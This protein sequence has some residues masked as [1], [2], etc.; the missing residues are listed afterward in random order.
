MKA[1]RWLAVGNLALAA[2]LM[3][4]VWVLMVWVGSR[5]ALKTLWDLTPQRVNSVDPATIELL[6]QLRG[7]KTAVQF[8]LMFPPMQGGGATEAEQQGLAIRDR[9]REL[10]RMLLRGY[11]FH[12]GDLVTISE[13]DFYADSA[14]TREA[15]QRF[16]YKSAELDTLV[17]AVQAEGRELR[18]RKLSLLVDLATIDLPALQPNTGP[19]QRAQV[20]VLKDFKG[21]EQISSALKSLLVQGT[22][23]AYFLRGYSPGV[24]FDGTSGSAYSGFQ[25]L[26]QNAGF[27]VRALDLRASEGRVPA[28]AAVVIV[29]EPRSEFTDRD[30]QALFDYVRFGGRVFLNYAWAGV[31]DWNPTGGKLGELLGYELSA[32][33]VF[34]LIM[35][36]VRAGRRGIDGPGVDKLQVRGNAAHPVTRRFVTG[37]RPLEVAAARAL[38]QRKGE[39]PG[40][41]HE[42]LLSTGDQAWIAGIDPRDGMPDL[43]R[44]GPAVEL[45]PYLVGLSISV[46]V[47]E[48]TAKQAKDGAP[49]TGEVIVVSGVFCNNT[50]VGL[51]GDLALNICNWMAERRVLLDIQ[52][53]RYEARHLQLSPQQLDRVGN[54]L[55]W[56]VPATFFVLG[57]VVFFVRRRI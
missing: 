44:P 5:P 29:M 28:D 26:L 31:P 35:D 37:G 19:M 27:D 32:A 24:D 38:G 51:F 43:R 16:D 55:V 39:Y 54:L 21:E 42:E 33:P 1:R 15:A 30:A 56:G 50:G 9:L 34:H 3:L 45:R 57:F 6:E 17:V 13:P 47:D 11:Q 23:V 53:S 36:S 52:G 8:H 7:A 14:S 41:R 20:P 40:M 22:P 10:T 25:A 18:Y 48:A 46:D 2:A 4:V 12:G 49:R